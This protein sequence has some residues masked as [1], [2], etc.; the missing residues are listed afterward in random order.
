MKIIFSLY[1]LA[2]AIAIVLHSL[3]MGMDKDTISPARTPQ[4]FVSSLSNPQGITLSYQISYPADTPKAFR[5]LAP[6]EFI[7]AKR[8]NEQLGYLMI[9]EGKPSFNIWKPEMADTV[10]KLTKD[11]YQ[12]LSNWKKK[13][14]ADENRIKTSA[15]KK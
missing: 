13:N 10:K 12:Q 8:N 6:T 5:P 7:V 1:Q 2:I 11:A 9:H 15:P 4:E 3:C 14:D